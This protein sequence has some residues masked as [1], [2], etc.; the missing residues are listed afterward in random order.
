MTNKKRN[1]KTNAKKT[2]KRHALSKWNLSIM[3]V[4]VLSSFAIG[5]CSGDPVIGSVL[6]MAGMI[7]SYLSCNQKRQG[8]IFGAI[9]AILLAYLGFVN[10]LY[11]SFFLNAFIYAPLQITG[12]FAWGKYQDRN[13]N[14]RIRKLTPKNAF[15]L[16]TTCTAGSLIVGYGLTMVPSQQMAFLDSAVCCIQIA[17]LI[18][19]NLRYAEAWWLWVVADIFAISM[20][21]IAYLEG[22]GGAFMSLLTTITFFGFDVY[23]L[24]KWHHRLAKKKAAKKQPAPSNR[25]TK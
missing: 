17:A 8:Y 5:I 2:N 12:L 18:I 23:G 4:C 6:L 21:R 22:G 19:Q 25:R 7:D 24:I 20:W 9:Y 13:H 16:I 10:H 11:G 15:I 14:V 3:G 1:T